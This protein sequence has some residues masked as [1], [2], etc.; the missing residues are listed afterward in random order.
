MAK[1][2]R[3]GLDQL[4]AA[5][6]GVKFHNQQ[7]GYVLCIVTNQSWETEY[8]VVDQVKQRPGGTCSTR[9]K[10]VVEAG[11]PKLHQA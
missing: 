1:T 5:N 11:A 3:K 9:A 10:F 2:N 6:P 7:R 4:M 8:I